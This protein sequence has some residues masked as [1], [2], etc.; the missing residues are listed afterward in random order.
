MYLVADSDASL[1]GRKNPV[2]SYAFLVSQADDMAH[3][4]N[5][6]ANDTF[7]GMKQVLQQ[8][9]WLNAED[10]YVSISY[11]ALADRY[12]LRWAR[13]G[14]PRSDSQMEL[15]STSD[16]ENIVENSSSTAPINRCGLMKTLS[17]WNTIAR[18][19]EA[20]KE[21]TAAW[22]AA[23]PTSPAAVA[24]LTSHEEPASLRVRQFL[25]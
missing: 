16:L 15:P 17:R 24:P 4:L 8:R 25:Y 9:H 19:I 3:M 18:A 2:C 21:K 14:L 20:G 12:L 13:D 6:I 10:I 22:Q 11:R 7:V 5:T 23:D 1:V